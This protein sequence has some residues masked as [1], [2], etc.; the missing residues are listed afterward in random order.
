M[1][2]ELTAALAEV[3]VRSKPGEGWERLRDHIGLTFGGRDTK[4]QLDAIRELWGPNGPRPAETG[5]AVWLENRLMEKPDAAPEL[6]AILD[7]FNKSS[8]AES[9]TPSAND[10]LDFRESTFHGQ[11]VGVQYNHHVPPGGQLPD[12]ASWPLLRKADPIAL[13]VRSAR[14]FDGAARARCRRFP[15]GHGATWP[16]Y[17]LSAT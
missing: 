4:T 9:S 15:T 3:L 2:G 1:I 10:H 11:V 16:T 13:G 17:S 7:E 12:P 8:R 5:F 14:C 6:Q